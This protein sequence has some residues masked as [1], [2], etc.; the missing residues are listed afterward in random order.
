MKVV[1]LRVAT[2]F[3]L[4]GLVAFTASCDPSARVCTSSP[5]SNGKLVQECVDTDGNVTYS[6][7]G[8]SCSCSTHSSTSCDTCSSRVDAYCTPAATP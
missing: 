3:V 5:C 6:F 8:T 1:P 2:R 7:G 4:L